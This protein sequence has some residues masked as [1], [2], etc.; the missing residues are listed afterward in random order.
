MMNCNLIEEKLGYTFRNKDILIE[1]LTHSSS[2]DKSNERLEF[3]G[4][5]V[6]DLVISKMIYLYDNNLSEGDMTLYRSS[7]VR[8]SNLAEIARNLDV[9]KFLIV[10]RSAE[11]INI[12]ENDSIL[13]NAMEALIGGVF[14]D[15]GYD[16]SYS[17]IEK[18]FSNSFRKVLNRDCVE[19]YKSRFQEK[20]QK[21]NIQYSIEYRVKKVEGPDHDST[22]HIELYLNDK[23][24]SEG[25]GKSKKKA[26][27][28]AAKLG[29][30]EV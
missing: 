12:R 13:E 4:D 1:A 16:I 19:D 22:F 2:G 18:V 7:I 14:L 20:I 23:F 5:S 28:E 17:L 10:G 11:N 6:L 3:L 21:N 24:I 29:L 27:M 9:D 15:G 25:A 8:G 30:M 26:E